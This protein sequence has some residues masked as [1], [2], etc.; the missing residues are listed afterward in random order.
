MFRTYLLYF[1]INLY[2]LL[3]IFHLL[4]SVTG[5]KAFI[6][7]NRQH[8][9]CLEDSTVTGEVMLK[10]C[11]LDSRLQQWTWINEG[12]LMSVASSR[13]LSALQSEPV[14]TQSCDGLE[15]DS[16]G[17]MWDC[18]RDMLISRATSMLL[19]IE[20]RRLTFTHGSKNSKWRSLDKGDICQEKVSKFKR[21]KGTQMLVSKYDLL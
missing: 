5:A 12:M 7:Y 6:I 16:T 2:L 10:E 20:G 1:G 18:D 19:S 13:C 11:N 9:L 4:T 14:T 15:T 17:Q 8:S 21:I 3:L